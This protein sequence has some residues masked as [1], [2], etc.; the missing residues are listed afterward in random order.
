MFASIMLRLAIVEELQGDRVL[1][2]ALEPR[3]VIVLQE[4]TVSS[5]VLLKY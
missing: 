4:L 5:Y 1:E 3:Y 2:A